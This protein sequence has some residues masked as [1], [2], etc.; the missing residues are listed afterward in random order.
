ML[1][2][3]YAPPEAFQ[4]DLVVLNAE[5]SRHL[6]RVLRLPA[7]ARVAVSDGR[8]RQV[9]AEVER[10]NPD[11]AV[12]R[13]VRE[14]PL[15]GESPLALTLGVGLAKGD[16]LDAVIRQATEMGVKTIVPFVSAHSE[17]PTPERAARRLSRWRRLARES[18]KSC[19]RALLPEIA[20]VRDFAEVLGD[21]EEAKIIFWEE[22]RGG[23]LMRL[24]SRP[25]PAGVRLLIGPEG[26][27]APVEVEQARQAGYQTAS[28]GPRR[29]RVETAA[30]AALSL[31]QFAWGD[32]A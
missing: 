20:A 2:R 7:G 21:P 22:E 18:L 25:R 4:G 23:G 5:E 8:G 28:L 16:V 29:L 6:T 19:Q 24:L 1:R 10:P 12:L 3:F 9:E 27:F 32:L 26:G 14:L 17:K 15:G 30:L 13:V 11:A 31:V